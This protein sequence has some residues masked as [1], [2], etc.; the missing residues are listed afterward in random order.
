MDIRQLTYF[1]ATAEAGTISRA[2]ERCGI[3]QPSLSQQVRKLED[4]LGMDLFDRVGK[5]VVLT[6]AGRALLPRARR[7]LADVREAEATIKRES[8]AGA[9]TISIGAIPTMAPYLLPRGVE[10]L[11]HERPEAEIMIQEALTEQLIDALVDM[12]I[13][14]AVVSTPIVHDQIDVE[15]IGT[16]ALLL[17]MPVGHA[18]ADRGVASWMDLRG[19]P[20][21]TLREMHCLG[22]QIEGFCTSRGMAARVVCRTAQLATVFELVGLGLGVSIVPEMAAVH[23]GTEKWRY[24]RLTGE[25]PA[26]EI[27]VAWRKDRSRANGARRLVELIAEDLRAG[28]HTLQGRR[29]GTR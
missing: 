25:A 6:D 17:A 2:A 23:E 12:V 11:R 16:E 3:A 19:E 7:I 10:R 27:A 28:R 14:C 8:E 24:A 18:R 9:G 26:R 15:V 20:T 21:V 4:S 1:V 5:G 22:R 13:D 29:A